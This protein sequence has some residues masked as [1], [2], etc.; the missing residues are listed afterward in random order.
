MQGTAGGLASYDI[1]PYVKDQPLQE[2][3]PGLYTGTYVVPRG[4]NFA[5][6]PV[7]GHLNARGSDAPPAESRA[8]VTVAT[9]I[10]DIVDF[11]PDNGAT[12]NN[13]RP[14]IYATFQSGT[15]RINQSSVRI[16]VNGH[17]VTSSA[18]R[19]D[20]FIHSTPGI[21]YPEGAVHVTV[22]V[23]DVAGNTAKRSWTFFIKK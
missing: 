10:P 11:A 16:Q 22:Y 17:D 9:D 14:S 12:V 2:S 13:E 7:F 3:Q 19:T 23:S 15:A 21:D 18:M 4:V 1:G 6:A 20:R 5:N 8:T